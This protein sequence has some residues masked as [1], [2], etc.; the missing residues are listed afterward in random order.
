[1]NPFREE[2]FALQDRRLQTLPQAMLFQT[3]KLP[4]S[5]LDQKA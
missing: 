5:E 2:D 3:R 4:Q 1:M